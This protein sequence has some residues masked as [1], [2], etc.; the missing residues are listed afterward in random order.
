[1]WLNNYK[2]FMRTKIL[3]IISSFLIPL[4]LLPAGAAYAQVSNEL[5]SG[6]DSASGGQTCGGSGQPS[7]QDKLNSTIST[8][9]NI[10]SS[11]VGVLAVIMIIVAG[12]RYVTSGG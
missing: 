8:I 1:M 5:Q 7:C 2:H 9:V 12:F 3:L 4:T 6:V 10:L 11:L